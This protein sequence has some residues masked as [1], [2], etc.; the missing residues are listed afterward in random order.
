MTADE[1]LFFIGQDEDFLLGLFQQLDQMKFSEREK[2]AR[3]LEGYFVDEVVNDQGYIIP[4]SF[5]D[6]QLNQLQNDLLETYSEDNVADQIMFTRGLVNERLETIDDLMIRLEIESGILGA[7]VFELDIVL[8]EIDRISDGFVRGAYGDDEEEFKGSV[9][10]V[11]ESMERFRLDKDKSEFTLRSEI[12]D[13]LQKDANVGVNH[14]NSV[15]ITSMGSIDRKLRRVQSAEAGVDHGLYSGTFDDII[16]DFCDKW[17]GQVEAWDFWDTLTNDM[18]E[19]FFDF[20]VSQYCGGINCRHRIVPWD[21]SW[22]DGESDLRSRFTQ[23][24]AK[25]RKLS[26]TYKPH[27]IKKA[28]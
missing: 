22:S 12:V 11:R 19:G 15:A 14:A 21:L 23:A 28:S 6:Q 9:E 17:L 18:P 27:R 25:A 13:T 7:D 4:G 8:D 10:R 24:M 20:P 2:F 1:A 16:R 3:I 26:H 5:T